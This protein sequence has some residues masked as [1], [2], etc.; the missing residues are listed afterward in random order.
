MDSKSARSGL[1]CSTRRW[2]TGTGDFDYRLRFYYACF[3]NKT[4]RGVA[5]ARGVTLRFR[6]RLM[7]HLNKPGQRCNYPSIDI[8]SLGYAIYKR[9]FHGPL[10]RYK[11]LLI[12]LTAENRLCD[13]ESEPH[14]A[15]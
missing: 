2:T 9:S 4:A 3:F 12:A 15:S 10:L 8:H 1:R 13:H 11:E 7:I 14:I 5:V 6:R